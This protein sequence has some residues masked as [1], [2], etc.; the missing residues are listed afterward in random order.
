MLSDQTLRF[1]TKRL[2]SLRNFNPALLS[3]IMFLNILR[4][5][6]TSERMDMQ[7][8]TSGKLDELR[9]LV[10]PILSEDAMSEAAR[11]ALLKDL[12]K[13]REHE[14]GSRSGDDIEDVHQMRVATRRMR[15]IFQLLGEY[16]KARPVEQYQLGLRKVAR[17]LGEVRDL[18]VMIDNLTRFQETLSP[19]DQ[20]ALSKPIT[21]LSDRRAAERKKLVSALDKKDYAHFVADFTQFV[22]TAGAGARA[23]SKTDGAPTEVRH[24]LPVTIYEHLASVRAY[25]RALKDADDETLHLLRIEFKRLRY[26]LSIFEEVLGK[27]GKDF[28]EELKLLSDHLGSLQ[29]AVVAQTRLRDLLPK[30]DDGEKAVLELYM[31]TLANEY[32]GLRASFPDAW[33]RFNTRAVQRQLG[34]AISGL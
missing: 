33:K 29:D 8:M 14:K 17:A 34:S 3:V 12:I 5:L 31:G 10:A 22:S 9:N 20:A 27:A 19:E 23:L 13:M 11:K 30:L 7:D 15:S 16:F 32:T 24:I 25:D 6:Q 26:L 18:D 21:I 2:S 28:G 1:L 4:Y